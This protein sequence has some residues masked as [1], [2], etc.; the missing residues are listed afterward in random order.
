LDSGGDRF[1]LRK[2][3]ERAGEGATVILRPPQFAVRAEAGGASALF[4][5]PLSSPGF[6]SNELGFERAIPDSE[7]SGL[8]TWRGQ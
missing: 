7:D 1:N 4:D 6:D 3:S 5:A 8:E 2:V